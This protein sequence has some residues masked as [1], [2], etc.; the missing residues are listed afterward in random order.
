MNENNR[1]QSDVALAEVLRIVSDMAKSQKEERD[2]TAT[3]RRSNDRLIASHKEALQKQAA[4][5]DCMK[6]HFT[7]FESTYGPML[8]ESFERRKFWDG[9]FAEQKKRSALVVTGVMAAAI[10]Y[11]MGHAVVYLLRQFRNFVGV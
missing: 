10:L 3:Y 9:I 6:D 1:R 2:T 8:Q 4:A 5:I 11:G 7:K